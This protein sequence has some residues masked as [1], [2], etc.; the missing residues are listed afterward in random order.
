MFQLTQSQQNS[1]RRAIAS[2]CRRDEA[3]AVADVFERGTLTAAEREQ[4]QTVA[5]KLAEK[6]RHKTDKANGAAA[7]LRQFS[8]RDAGAAGFIQAIQILPHLR[9][10]ATALAFLQERLAVADWADYWKYSQSM[11]ENMAVWRRNSIEIDANADVQTQAAS[12]RLAA[13]RTEQSIQLLHEH[14]VF[15]DKLEEAIKVSR[16]WEKSGFT[17]QYQLLCQSAHTQE[18]AEQNFQTYVNA[19][20]AL[21]RAAG[22]VGV[23]LANGL[24]IKLSALFPRFEYAQK[25]RVMTELLP[26]LKKLFQLGKDYHI[27]LCLDSEYS[28]HLELSLDIFEQL[29]SEPRLVDYHGMGFTV[30]AQHKSAPFVLEYLNSLAYGYKKRLMVRLIEGV[31]WEEEIRRAQQLGL[32]GYPVYTRRDYMRIAYLACARMLLQQAEVMYPQFATHDA[33]LVAAIHAMGQAKTFEFQAAFGEDDLL[34]EQVV[35]RKKLERACRLTVPV[36]EMET[37]LPYVAARL[38]AHGS[39]GEFVC[40]VA[41]SAVALADLA[42]CP[43]DVA[44]E[45]Q[46]AP[47]PDVDLPRYLFL[48]EGR[49]NAI[50]LDLNDYLVLE[51]LQER[52]NAAQ[53]HGFQAVSLLAMNTPSEEPHFVQNPA[54]YGDVVGA[55]SFTNK[56]FVHNTVGAAKAVESRWQSV[57][58]EKRA[59]RLYAYADALELAL[60]ELMALIVRETGKTLSAAV[61]EVR[62]TVDYCRYYAR[63]AE[64]IC[65]ERPPLGTVAVIGAW[66]SPLAALVGQT[67]AALAVG[68][69]VIV[70][71]AEQACLTAYRAIKLL[72]DTGIPCPAAQLL[73]GGGDVA[74]EL[75]YDRRIN[76][77]LFTGKTETAKLINHTLAQRMDLPA[78][79]TSTGGQNV[80][81]ADL[82]VQPEKVCADIL[83]AAFLSTGTTGNALKLVCVP[84]ELADTII[85]R[86]QSLMDELIVGNPMELASDVGAMIDE[87]SYEQACVYIQKMAALGH[88]CYQS[89]L[90][91]NHNGTGLFVPPTL[92]EIKGL[93]QLQHDMFAPVLHIYRYRSEDLGRMID[94]INGKGYALSLAVHS[95]IR[96]IREYAANRME[97]ANI[98]LNSS[99]LSPAAGS[100]PFGGRGFSGSGAQMG[101]YFYA[102]SL[103]HGAWR[104]PH[105]RSEAVANEKSVQTVETLIAQCHFEHD[106]R[107]RLAG[108]AAQVRLHTLRLA[109]ASLPAC[110]GYQHKM[111]WRSPRHVWIYG[112]SLETALS[113]LL[114][115]AAAGIHAVVHR[116][117][118]LAGFAEQL[119]NVMRVSDNPQ[120]QPFVSHMVALDLPTPEIKTAL[121]ARNGSIVRIVDAREGLD[122]VR[123]FDEVGWYEY[124]NE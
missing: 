92:V 120:Q 82:S 37:W 91:E 85:H 29:V 96:E 94:Q 22:K 28:E 3:Q 124:V 77:V 18:E 88:F 25:G 7:L 115:M 111:T 36:G 10:E 78:L 83:Q 54:D 17:V 74:H 33:Y 110:R 64:T 66:D 11:L 35:G 116:D 53:E 23:L 56:R 38:Q 34:Y 57:S 6:I 97:A 112:G 4:A 109:E 95:H 123:L 121:A 65:A 63:Q 76:G 75:A 73:L 32:N 16:K 15:H 59:E 55:T 30:Q 12:L 45:T 105:L 8:T 113:A 21:G 9:D 39:A 84:N 46:G 72:H 68:N 67:I 61:S 13:K 122:I 79:S 98:F 60:P 70:K 93:E 43:L 118:L 81:I 19:V 20:Y 49:L 102:Q 26:K 24:L 107:V 87:E 117:H 89:R 2:A 41:D 1:L 62:Q 42:R 40:D 31:D 69:I 114:A 27:P 86:L 99:I 47:N 108:Q 80:L 5:F 51:R 119:S 90:P 103:G 106:A 14:L 58:P 52:M 48:N 100:R 50:G 71:P 101:G 104:I 44:L